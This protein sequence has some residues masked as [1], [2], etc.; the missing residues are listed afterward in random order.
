M[1][2]LLLELVE[3]HI[4]RCSI[5]FSQ[6]LIKSIK[7]SLTNTVYTLTHRNLLFR[8]DPEPNSEYNPEPSPDP[9]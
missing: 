4:V 3:I 8:P 9:I 2:F 5:A 6:F 7:N 1:I